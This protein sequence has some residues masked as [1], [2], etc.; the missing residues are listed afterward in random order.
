MTAPPER[1]TFERVY[2]EGAA[3]VVRTVRRL[4]VPK[5]DVF[6]AAQQ[7][8]LTVHRRLSSFD[9]SSQLNTW[10]FGISRRVAADFRDRAHLRREVPTQEMPELSAPPG[11]PR[12]I[13]RLEA[14]DTLDR[15]LEALDEDKRAVFVLYELEEWTMPE[16]AA[17]IGCPVQTAYT[18][19][20]AGR[21]LVEDALRSEL[22]EEGPR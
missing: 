20:R 6:D 9:G 15:F 19:Y 2:A 14:R 13:E 4:G 11:P 21:K 10:L 7:V 18:R 16:V 8:F 3:F 12:D 5:D 1:L 22:G 17:A